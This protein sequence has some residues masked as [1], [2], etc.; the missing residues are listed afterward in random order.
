[1]QVVYVVN[2]K[3]WCVGLL[4]GVGMSNNVF[5]ANSPE[6][7]TAYCKATTEPYIAR[8][9]T[10][11]WPGFFSTYDKSYLSTYIVSHIH[12]YIYIKIDRYTQ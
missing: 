8:G 7:F 2:F 11:T 5:I 3:C 4:V 12:R 1:M 10:R 6:L 9:P